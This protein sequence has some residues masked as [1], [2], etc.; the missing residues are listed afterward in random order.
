MAT[1]FTAFRPSTILCSSASSNRRKPPSSSSSSA[2]WWNPLFGWP[3]DPDY[4]TSDNKEPV[5]RTPRSSDSDPGRAGPRFRV[6]CF[7]EEKARELRRKTA[8]ITTFHDVMYH[9][10]IASRLA[11]GTTSEK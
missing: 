2:N 11:S 8:E 9:S 10:A 3:T 4:I 6:G 5:E 7:T 1:P